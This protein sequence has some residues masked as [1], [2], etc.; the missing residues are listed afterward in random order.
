MTLLEELKLFIKSILHWI[1]A[2]IGFSF[3]FFLFGLRTVTIYGKDVMLPLV[4]GD[5][6]AVQF[7]KIMQNDFM[8][9]GVALIVTSPMSGFITQVELAMTLAF[10]VVSP[11]FLY[12][13][14]KYL[15]PAL[16]EHEKK[17]IFKSLVLSS[18]LF[19]LG[20]LFAYFYMIPLTF[21]FM[22]PFTTALGVTPFFSL[23]VFMSWVIGILLATGITFLFPIFM[24]ILSF[25]GVVSPNFWRSKWRHALVCLLVFSALITPDQTGITMLLLFIP[26]VVLYIVGAML[27]GR[28]AQR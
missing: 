13:I 26:L 12:R 2:L 17:A 28:A 18:V 6:F 1:Y 25:M 21:K 22:Y 5:S 7:F 8:P 9:S 10:I 20:C 16:F 11:L 3:F 24:I 23:D 15:S 14:M 27:A 19:L 4:G